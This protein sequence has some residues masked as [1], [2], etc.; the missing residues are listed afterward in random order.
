MWNPFIR[1]RKVSFKT[2]H[3]GSFILISATTGNERIELTRECH[4]ADEA[5]AALR[6]LDRQLKDFFDKQD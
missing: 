3:G 6:D 2:P 1:S 5:L 4:T